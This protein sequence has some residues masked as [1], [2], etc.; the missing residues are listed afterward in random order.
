MMDEDQI[1]HDELNDY[2]IEMAQI[3]REKEPTTLN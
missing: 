1:I 2:D 3:D